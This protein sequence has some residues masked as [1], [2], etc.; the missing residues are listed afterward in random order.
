MVEWN[1]CDIHRLLEIERRFC[2]PKIRQDIPKSVTAFGKMGIWLGCLRDEIN[3]EKKLFDAGELADAI[4]IHRSYI[5]RW[6]QGEEIRKREKTQ[7]KEDM[8]QA[9][10]K[11]IRFLLLGDPRLESKVA[12]DK[13]QRSVKRIEDYITGN[14]PVESY[15]FFQEPLTNST[16]PRTVEQ[17]AYA[18]LWLANQSFDKQRSGL[19]H[20]ASGGSEF[21]Q[22]DNDNIADVTIAATIANVQAFFVCP[23]YKFDGKNKTSESVDR[24]FNKARRK[25]E[26]SDFCDHAIDMIARQREISFDEAAAVRFDISLQ[27]EMLKRMVKISVA[28]NIVWDPKKRRSEIWSGQFFNP[29]FRFVRIQSPL[30]ESQFFISRKHDQPFAFEASPEE[31]QSFTLWCKSVYAE[32]SI[33]KL[34][35]YELTKKTVKKGDA[36]PNTTSKRQKSK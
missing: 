23:K 21:A 17:A 14:N 5:S 2:A 25:I 34:N 10:K 18:I 24:F 8:W 33:E 6:F 1:G 30:D 35:A 26:D 22:A 28:P 19:F 4:G 3:A 13:R 7:K 11:S 29:V 12:D 9:A 27:E 20:L 16:T 31:E 32:P 36:H 15:P